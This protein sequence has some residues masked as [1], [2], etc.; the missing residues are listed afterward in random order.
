MNLRVKIFIFIIKSSISRDIDMPSI[1][2]AIHLN[3]K[4]ISFQCCV[5]NTSRVMFIYAQ[6]EKNKY[7][8]DPK[9]QKSG[10]DKRKV[11]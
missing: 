6:I 5:K 3:R 11:C 4:N 1:R 9:N 7:K 2:G 10:S 8:M